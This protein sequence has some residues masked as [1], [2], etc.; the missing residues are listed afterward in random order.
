[1]RIRIQEK[2]ELGQLRLPRIKPNFTKSEFRKTNPTKKGWGE[3]RM[4]FMDG[5]YSFLTPTNSKLFNFECQIRLNS[6]TSYSVKAEF[7]FVRD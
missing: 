4:S 7:K 1:M 2:N 3:L 5:P 6:D